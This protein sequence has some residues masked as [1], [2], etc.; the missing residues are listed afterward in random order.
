[1]NNKRREQKIEF[2]VVGAEKISAEPAI[3]Q[4]A[5]PAI[6]FSAWWLQIQQAK[7]L[8][9]E[10]REALRKHFE[11]RGFLASGEFE[12]GLKDFGL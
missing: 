11:S 12:E 2:T 4:P 5:R 6:S 1:M 8:K 9:F 3:A 10:L 7:Q